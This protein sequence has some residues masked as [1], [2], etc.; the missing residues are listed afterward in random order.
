MKAIDLAKEIADKLKPLNY[1]T[2]RKCIH[3]YS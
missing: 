2:P 3:P 1:T